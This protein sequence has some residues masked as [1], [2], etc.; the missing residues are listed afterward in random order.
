MDAEIERLARDSGRAP[1][2][3]RSLLQ[4]GGELAAM[5]SGLREAKVLKLLVEHANIQPGK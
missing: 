1:Q 2:A 5:R 4:R 3:V